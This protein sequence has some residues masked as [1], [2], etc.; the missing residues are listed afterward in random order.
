MQEPLSPAELVAVRREAAHTGAPSRNRALLGHELRIGKVRALVRALQRWHRH[1]PEDALDQGE[2]QQSRDREPARDGDEGHEQQRRRHHHPG[3]HRRPPPGD[4]VLSHAPQRN[5]HDVDEGAPLSIFRDQGH[6]LPLQLA[7]GEG[8]REA[9][10]GL[11]PP[12]GYRLSGSGLRAHRQ[13]ETLALTAGQR[14]KPDQQAELVVDQIPAPDDPAAHNGAVRIRHHDVDGTPGGPTVGADASDDAGEL[15]GAGREGLL[16]RCVGGDRWQGRAARDVRL[17][18][19]GGGARRALK[20]PERHDHPP[21]LDQ[22]RR[23]L[24]ADSTTVGGSTRGSVSVRG[25]S[26]GN[27]VGDDNGRQGNRAVPTARRI[28]PPHGPLR[29]RHGH[30]VK[31]RGAPRTGTRR[32]RR[33]PLRAGRQAPLDR[34][35]S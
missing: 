28:P 3:H 4:S 32:R 34:R 30:A 7:T 16:G 13:V 1:R 29:R 22:D 10:A 20:S 35:A 11:G 9:R 24:D 6:A 21:V 8:G 2:A 15:V 17:P 12:K 27:R 33:S 31:A 25:W 14:T 18:V 26:T 19:Q 23:P 5:A